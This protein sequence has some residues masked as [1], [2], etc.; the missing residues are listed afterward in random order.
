MNDEQKILQKH[1]AQ[2]LVGPVFN[3]VTKDDILRIKAHNVW[4]HKGVLLNEG[5][6]KALKNEAAAFYNSALWKT[7]KSE[8]QYQAYQSGYV[9]SKTESDQI[10][11]KVLEYLVK[12]VDDRLREMTE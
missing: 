12:V 7:L 11:A 9:K 8:L 3:T 10:S 1:L 4:E 5:Q 2:F 6:V